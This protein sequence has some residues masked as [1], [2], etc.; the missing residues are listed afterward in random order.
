MEYFKVKNEIKD[1]NYHS[2]RKKNTEKEKVNQK[3]N[4]M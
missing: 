1:C 3:E 2:L 4:R